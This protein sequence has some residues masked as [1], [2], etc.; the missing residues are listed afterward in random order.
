MSLAECQINLIDVNFQLQKSLENFDKNSADKICAYCTFIWQLE[1]EWKTVWDEATFEKFSCFYKPKISF[2][3]WKCKCKFI[4]NL[5][6]LWDDR[7]FTV[8]WQ[9]WIMTLTWLWDLNISIKHFIRIF[10]Q[11]FCNLIFTCT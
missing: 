6:L 7:P 3:V 10:L 8:F 11:T 9:R 1:S 5:A 4:Q 2:R